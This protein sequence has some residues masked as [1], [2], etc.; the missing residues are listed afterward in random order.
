VWMPLQVLPPSLLLHRKSKNCFILAQRESL[1]AFPFYFLP[2]A[3]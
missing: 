1:R 3:G 2:K